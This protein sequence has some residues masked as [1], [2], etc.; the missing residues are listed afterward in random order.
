MTLALIRDLRQLGNERRS[1]AGPPEQLI[2]HRQLEGLNTKKVAV[3]TDG[4]A[5]TDI[6]LTLR[7][8]SEVRF[9]PERLRSYADAVRRQEIAP[10]G[11]K[12]K[13]AYA[14]VYF[15][16]LHFAIRDEGCIRNQSVYIA[17]ALDA[18]WCKIILGFWVAQE[19]EYGFWVSVLT[20]LKARG[21]MELPFVIV[22]DPKG[23]AEALRDVFDRNDRF[24][25][26]DNRL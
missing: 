3:Y 22:E 15:H 19:D 16:L 10:F 21:L 17:V 1:T 8:L 5:V 13:A 25:E 14:I 2:G 23:F 12:L 7:K 6:A 18:V 26:A 24:G 11:D 4:F 9:S 20:D